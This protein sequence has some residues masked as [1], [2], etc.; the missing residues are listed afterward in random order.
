MPMEAIAGTVLSCLVPAHLSS[1]AAVAWRLRPNRPDPAPAERPAVS[2]V[3]PLRGLEPHLEANLA[4]TFALDWP[5]YEIL[6]CVADPEDPVIPVAQRLIAAH[7]EVEAR[8][9][10]GDD[11]ISI[12]PKLNNTVK[13]FRAARHGW[14]LM[15]DSNVETPPDLLARL[16]A[17]WGPDTGLACSPPVGGRAEGFWA[18]L[19]CAFLDTYQTRVQLAADIAGFGFAQGKAMLYRRDILEAIGGIEAL[20]AEPAEDAATTKLLRA[21]GYR[22]RLARRP[23]VQALGRRT[24]A[25][26]WHRQVRWARLRR[27]TFPHWYSLEIFAGA[28]PPALALLALAPLEGWAQGPALLAFLA[29]WYGAEAALARIAGWHL[30]LRSLPAMLLRDLLLPA[31]WLAGWI[32]NGFVWRG[33]AMRLADAARAG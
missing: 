14:I 31:V 13:G 25:E 5:D 3:R 20:A 23:F 29:F 12:N 15:I 11:R 27:D 33:N 28:L 24:L 17:V 9:L 30:S 6:L 4:A 8:L 18:A 7:P 19:E 16:F 10:V 1:L 22:I 2:I 21:R 32:G 26:V